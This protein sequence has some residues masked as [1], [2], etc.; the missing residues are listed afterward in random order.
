MTMPRRMKLFR[1]GW[2]ER[3]DLE[4][5]IVNATKKM[6]TTSANTA[7]TVNTIWLVELKDGRN[8]S[9]TKMESL[10]ASLRLVRHNN[11]L[12]PKVSFPREYKATGAL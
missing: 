1:R 8:F 3:I 6:L 11:R 12:G 10:G 4:R 7:T 5:L 9:I 2:L